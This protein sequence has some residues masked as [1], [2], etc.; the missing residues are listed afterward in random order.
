MVMVASA[1]RLAIRLVFGSQCSHYGER[2]AL[3]L[4]CGFQAVSSQRANN[5]R[6]CRRMAW[7]FARSL[8]WVYG[9]VSMAD[10]H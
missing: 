6:N 1:E 2:I 8:H 3:R 4:S 10:F 7:M 5:Y 9:T